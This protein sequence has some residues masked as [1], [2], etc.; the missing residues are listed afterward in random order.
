MRIK[1]KKWFTLFELVIYVWI[2]II[3]TLLISSVFVRGVA[4]YQE[5]WLLN[6]QLHNVNNIETI[7][8][9]S[10]ANIDNVI[11]KYHKAANS[12][13]TW[14]DSDKTLDNIYYNNHLF[15]LDELRTTCW[16]VTNEDYDL[17]AFSSTDGYDPV[18]VWVIERSTDTGRNYR[19]LA[20]YKYY[21]TVTER[22][23]I[24]WDKI[25]WRISTFVNTKWEYET[26]GLTAY[27]CNIDNWFLIPISTKYYYDDEFDFSFTSFLKRFKADAT[28]RTN[29]IK[30]WIGIARMVF[31]WE[32]RDK[33]IWNIKHQYFTKKFRN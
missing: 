1:N 25:A 26:E 20:V 3:W 23:K 6:E 17:I 27:K 11:L 32:S 9:K 21:S 28:N 2:L 30:Y 24:L 29:N 5:S 22:S 33:T 4:K 14:V 12:K 8:K 13:L 16:F 19:Q 18:I 15:T 10:V 31:S 7:L